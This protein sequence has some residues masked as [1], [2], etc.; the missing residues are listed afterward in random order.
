MYLDIVSLL[1]TE[2]NSRILPALQRLKGCKSKPFKP[3]F[4]WLSFL[5]LFLTILSATITHKHSLFS[6]KVTEIQKPLCGCEFSVW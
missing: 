3:N 1:H 6:G 4:L 2:L 5:F